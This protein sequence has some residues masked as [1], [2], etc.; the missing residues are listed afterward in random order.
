M[1][2]L[3]TLPEPQGLGTPE[4]E[5][6]LS[7][8][9]RTAQ[10][11][12]VREGWLV[13]FITAVAKG[14]A[15]PS[16][17]CETN[18]FAISDTTALVVRGINELSTCHDVGLTTLLRLKPALDRRGHGL[19][20]SHYR[21][22]PS[23]KDPD[24]GIGYSMLAHQMSGIHFC[25]L[26]K[27]ALNNRCLSCGRICKNVRYGIASDRCMHC[28]DPMWTQFKTPPL[29]SAYDKWV[30]NQL[31]HLIA[32][33]SAPD[34]TALPSNWKELFLHAMVPL[35]DASTSYTRQERYFFEKL[36]ERHLEF[37][38]S[39]PTLSTLLRLASIQ[40][41]DLVGLVTD[42]IGSCSP[43]LLNIGGVSGLGGER[44][45]YSPEIW[46]AA[47][48]AA[49]EYLR[50]DETIPLPSKPE[51]CR[52]FSLPPSGFW[53]HFR[54]LSC[55]YTVERQRRIRLAH[56]RKVEWAISAAKNI[57]KERLASGEA[58]RIREDGSKIMRQ[59][60][61]PKAVVEKALKDAIAE[62]CIDA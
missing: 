56:A 18:H 62:M 3:L 11:Y 4:V 32:F 8:V 31:L 59:F 46:A 53:Q 49:R 28:D 50:T 45:N 61:A 55:K 6:L 26:H 22:C 34:A 23:C 38:K 10:A 20:A 5:S 33:V 48:K 19:F 60:G 43:R 24:R 25:P 2:W 41:C 1:N 21:W 9:I 27:I 35:R 7:L 15:A 47:E 12:C 16:Q 57:V 14:Q 39:L 13:N 52:V 40:A 54:E 42:P 17:V 37:P 30:E 29:L 44:K 51:L 58:V 36:L